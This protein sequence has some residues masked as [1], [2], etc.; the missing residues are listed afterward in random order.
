MKSIPTEKIIELLEK[1]R[2]A[3]DP[4]RYIN[5]AAREIATAKDAVCKDLQR[6]IDRLSEDPDSEIDEWA[7]AL[8]DNP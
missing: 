6:D 7:N 1:Y 2:E 3:Y 5:P 4:S 8:L